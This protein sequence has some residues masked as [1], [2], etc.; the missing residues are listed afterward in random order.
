MKI[1]YKVYKN[2]YHFILNSFTKSFP[3]LMYFLGN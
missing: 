3:K 1:Y 2:L